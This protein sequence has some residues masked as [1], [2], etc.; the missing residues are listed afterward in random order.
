[1]SDKAAICS[2][3]SALLGGLSLLRSPVE[4]SQNSALRS[5][6]CF[7]VSFLFLSHP[8]AQPGPVVLLR[9]ASARTPGQIYS[10]G[11]SLTELIWEPNKQSES[12]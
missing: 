8:Q 10:G 6:G 11:V 9:N 7:S 4:A 5:S 1:M 12:A 3:V 2:D